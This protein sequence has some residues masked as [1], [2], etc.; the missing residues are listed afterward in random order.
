MF[1]K[2][3]CILVFSSMSIYSEE[4]KVVK[5]SEKNYDNALGITWLLLMAGNNF[6]EYNGHKKAEFNALENQR[7]IYALGILGYNN[8]AQS[9]KYDYTLSVIGVAWMQNNL[10]NE[11]NNYA[12]GDRIGGGIWSSF[13]LICYL[14]CGTGKK[15]NNINPKPPDFS[16]YPILNLSPQ[17]GQV[18]IGFRF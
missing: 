13:A 5:G 10:A 4:K 17:A 11:N 3:I 14:Y 2:I 16:F 6:Y 18:G 1:K 9:F 12:D 15:Y 7:N 8:Q